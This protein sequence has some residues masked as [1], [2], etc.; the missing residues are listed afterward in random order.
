MRGRGNSA[1]LERTGLGRK[2]PPRAAPATRLSQSRSAPHLV[3]VASHRE[4]LQSHGT[5]GS[6]VRL[7]AARIYEWI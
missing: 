3:Y 5:C 6:A 2:S 1:T 4:S 7:L